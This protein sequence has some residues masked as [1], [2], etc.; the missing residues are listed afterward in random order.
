[1]TVATG[2]KRLG[3]AIVAGAWV[4]RR[5]AEGADRM[6][7]FGW[8]PATPALRG[9]GGVLLSGLD[10]LKRE[11]DRQGMM[12][13]MDSFTERDVNIVTSGRLAKALD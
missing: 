7:D 9:V 4:Q 10:R 11:I 2:V 6:G 8:A 3:I 5:A 1:M 12:T 13:A